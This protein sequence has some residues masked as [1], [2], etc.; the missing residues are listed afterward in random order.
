MFVRSLLSPLV[1]GIIATCTFATALAAQDAKPKPREFSTDV[2][3]VNTAGN[4]KVTT[5]S[6]Q[7]LLVLRSGIW[8]H[9]QK[10]GSIYG[11]IDGKESSN[12]LF[13]N[14]RSDIALNKVLAV[15]GLAAFDRN[16]FSGIS[17]RFEES[18]GL[19]AKLLQRPADH[20]DMEMGVSLN[21]QLSTADVKTNFASLHSATTFKHDFTKSAY[22]LQSAEFLPSFKVSQ[23]YR[24]NTESALVAPLSTHVAMK[25]SY[26]VRF[27]NLP[28]PGK[29]KS[30]RIF[31]SGLQFN[32]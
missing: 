21:Q 27:D 19:A 13:A 23:D 2:G 12:L 31:T 28:E 17:R 20:W 6:L 5:F 4:S 18:A 8:E 11:S 15:Y 26:V 10:F 29:Q 24:L 7:E 1:A 30:D 14:W 32:W 3:F 25:L 9:H 22:F 16:P